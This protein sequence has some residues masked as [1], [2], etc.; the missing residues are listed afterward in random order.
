LDAS[1]TKLG[2]DVDFGAPFGRI[3][4]AFFDVAGPDLSD[5]ARRL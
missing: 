1:T 2:L 5:P 3:E 4:H